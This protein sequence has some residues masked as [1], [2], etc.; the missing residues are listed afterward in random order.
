MTA[1]SS[2]K[3]TW[4]TGQR[5]LNL[6]YS[7][8]LPKGQ[9]ESFHYKGT[10]AVINYGHCVVEGPAGMHSSNSMEDAVKDFHSNNNI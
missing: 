6:Q 7:A 3:F 5:Q 4:N 8:D 2:I 9:K 1:R 10:H